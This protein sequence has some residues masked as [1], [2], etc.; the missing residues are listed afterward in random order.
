MVQFKFAFGL[1][2][3]I[4]VLISGCVNTNELITTSQPQNELKVINLSAQQ[5]ILNDKAI[6][7]T[8]GTGWEKEGKGMTFSSFTNKASS[9]YFIQYGKKIITKSDG[10]HVNYS[11]EISLYT[12]PVFISTTK[13]NMKEIS[14]TIEIDAIENDINIGDVGKIFSVKNGVIVMFIKNNVISEIHFTRKEY[15]SNELIIS[16]D[17]FNEESK[18]DAEIALELAKQQD[19]KISRILEMIK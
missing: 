10:G 14:K 4:I 16:G 8:L 6:E 15:T 7:E 3:L 18:V 12:Y 5:I 1:S 11:V 13:E 19:A 2:I 17:T 9:N